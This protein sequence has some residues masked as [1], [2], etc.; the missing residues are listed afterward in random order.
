MSTNPASPDIFLIT[1]HYTVH[2]ILQ[3]RILDWAAVPFSW[4]SS[5]PGIEL[6]SPA[7][8]ADSLPAEP[9]GKL[10]D[11]TVQRKEPI[12]AAHVAPR[13]FKIPSPDNPKLVT[14]LHMHAG[15]ANGDWSSR[16]IAF[17]LKD[18][19]YIIQFNPQISQLKKLKL[20][21]IPKVTTLVG[22]KF[23][24]VPSL[25]FTDTLLPHSPLL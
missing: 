21:G 3:A 25:L 13:C 18:T 19:L 5:Q 1:P 20:S 17:A 12:Q 7:L 15:Y 10:S 6:R 16:I 8:Q 22:A 2:G 4:R 9:P 23:T 14:L 11:Y 24:W